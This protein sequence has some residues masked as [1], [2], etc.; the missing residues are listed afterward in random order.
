PTWVHV[1]ATGVV[2]I[3]LSVVIL[4]RRARAGEARGGAAAA[5]RRVRRRPPLPAAGRPG[6]RDRGASAG[7]VAESVRRRTADVLRRLRGAHRRRD[8]RAPPDP[9][10]DGHRARQPE[11][12]EGCGGR[13]HGERAPD[14]A[15]RR[16]HRAV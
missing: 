15:L 12:R 13:V 1:L 2:T 8:P 11:P 7:Y 5:A 9:A 10:A 14:R 4:V 6:D 16:A 3:V